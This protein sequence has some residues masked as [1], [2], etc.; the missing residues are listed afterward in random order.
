MNLQLSADDVLTTTRAVRKRLDLER[1]V[2]RELLLECLQIAVQAPTGSNRQGWQWMFVEDSTKKRVIADYYRAMWEGYAKA[3][4]SEFPE[5]DPRARQR[6]TV[7]SS[8]QYL[9]DNFHRVPVMM[10][11]LL[12][13]RLDKG[14]AIAQAGAWGSILPAVWSYLLA[15]RAR[16]LG[17]AWTTLHLAH[18]KEVA[19]L[20]GVP[21]DKFTQAGLFP[22]AYTKGTDFKPA[23]RLPV[24]DIVHF[25]TW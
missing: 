14:P 5:D 18:E 7:L 24:D 9:A 3:R 1:P 19:E 25:D 4:L 15:L 23:G 6:P 12:E 10:I 20:L 21:Y 2:P 17:S 13:G 16:G 22:I 11:P 8:A